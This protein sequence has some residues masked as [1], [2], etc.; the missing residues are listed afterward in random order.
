[1]RQKATRSPRKDNVNSL[2]SSDAGSSLSVALSDMV[3]WIGSVGAANT[4]A[5]ASDAGEEKG[6][7]GFDSSETACVPL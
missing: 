2:L 7:A 6:F 1:M 4:A 5:Q 3:V